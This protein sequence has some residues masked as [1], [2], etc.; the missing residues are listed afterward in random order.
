MARTSKLF[1]RLTLRNKSMHTATIP[2][3]LTGRKGIQR[4]CCGMKLIKDSGDCSAILR[5]RQFR[6]ISRWSMKL[7]CPAELSGSE[8]NIASNP[9][10][11]FGHC[12]YSER[13]CRTIR[14]ECCPFMDTEGMTFF[15]SLRSFIA[16]QIPAIRCSTA[17]LRHC[18]DSG[19]WLRTWQKPSLEISLG[20]FPC[21]WSIGI[22]GMYFYRR[23]RLVRRQHSSL[24]P[25]IGQP[26]S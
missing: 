5:L 6:W 25:G 7:S 15:L 24:Y 17:T 16:T 19:Y 1:R 14:R 18:L 23:Y 4:R 10:K 2:K 20:Q 9:Q 8:L 12:I 11:L 21:D 13:I 3:E 22:F 26:Q